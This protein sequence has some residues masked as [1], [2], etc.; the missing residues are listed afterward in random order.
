MSNIRNADMN[1]LTAFDALFDERSVTR[2]ADRLALTQP[3]VSGMLKRLRATFSD[4]LFVRT[5]RGILPTPRAESLAGP[6]KDLL[7]NAR[8][9]ITPGAFNPALAEGTIRLSGS[10]YLQYALMSPLIAEIRKQAPRMNVQVSPRPAAGVADLL[11]RGEIDLCISA[12]EVALPD[13]PSRP[14]YRDRYICVART[15]HP[16]R[17]KRITTEQLCSF[18]HLLVDPTGRSLGGPVD[19]ILNS[20]GHRRRVSVA[21]PSFPFLFELLERE[22]FLAFVPERLV[23]ARRSKLKVFESPLVMPPIEVVANWHPRVSRDAQHKWLRGLLLEVAQSEKPAGLSKF[24]Y[25]RGRQTRNL[26]RRTR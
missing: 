3:T 7:A 25:D 1:L 16:L 11:A 26:T 13:L 5:S 19:E 9:L 8:S 10:D 17:T 20:L 23:R 6:I 21:V 4:P 12:R 18:E 15:K 14:L 24:S 2:A 22:N